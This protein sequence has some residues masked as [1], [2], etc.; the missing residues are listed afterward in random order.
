MKTKLIAGFSIA[1][2]ILLYITCQSLYS[3]IQAQKDIKRLKSNQVTLNDSVKYY[4][5]RSGRETA[6]VDLLQ[7]SIDEIK[8]LMPEVTETLRQLKIKPRRAES[9]SQTEVQ[10]HKEIK[11]PLRDTTILVNTI[12]TP[13]Q[14]FQYTDPWYDVIGIVDRT[15][16]DLKIN[17]TDTITQVVSRGDR[18]K[19]WLWFFSRRKLVQTIQSRNPS[20]HIVYSR[21]IKVIP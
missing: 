9:F 3:Y 20:N 4:R 5:D 21:Y 19:P 6:Q 2:I 8:Q 16:V 14:V 12:I 15:S 1:G 13:V 11:A 17:S 18:I 7:Y 10:Q